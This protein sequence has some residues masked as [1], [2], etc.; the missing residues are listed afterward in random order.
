VKAMGAEF[1]LKSPI[2]KKKEN[3]KKKKKLLKIQ[4]ATGRGV[5]FQ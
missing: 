1:T 5:V 4:F 2:Q 3:M